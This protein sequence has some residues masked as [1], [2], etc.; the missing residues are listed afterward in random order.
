VRPGRLGHVLALTV[1]L[2]VLTAASYGS[3]SGHSAASVSGGPQAASLYMGFFIQASVP[4]PSGWELVTSSISKE[5]EWTRTISGCQ[6]R[7]ILSGG[8][9]TTSAHIT[10][11]YSAGHGAPA[12][13]ASRGEIAIA[14]RGRV[15]A[16][17]YMQDGETTLALMPGWVAYSPDIDSHIDHSQL[18]LLLGLTVLSTPQGCFGTHSDS[19]DSLETSM[20][21]RSE[22]QRLPYSQTLCSQQFPGSSTSV[23]AK[24]CPA[25][26]PATG[27]PMVCQSLFPTASASQLAQWCSEL[28]GRD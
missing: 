15:T 14:G 2:P 18:V 20:L 10:T 4:P 24:N 9:V 21:N 28:V 5:Q 26:L 11:F 8:G 23:Q 19:L 6:E 22:F 27:V 3:S 12:I 13:K 17:R 25:A 7:M 16:L 1:M